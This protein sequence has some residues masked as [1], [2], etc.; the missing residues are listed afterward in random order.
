MAS[1]TALH[2][3]PALSVTAAQIVR[4]DH[5]QSR[6]TELKTAF[7]AAKP[8]PFIILD[9]FFTAA[10]AAEIC[11]HI[12]VMN[13]PGWEYYNHTNKQKEIFVG[14][15]SPY[16]EEV[17]RALNDDELLGFFSALTGIQN[18]V[19]DHAV[20]PTIHRVRRD[21]YMNLHSDAVTVRRKKGFFRREFTV[22]IFMTPDWQA[23]YRGNLELW[24]DRAKRCVESVFPK[25]NRCVIFKNIPKGFHGLPDP[26]LCPPGMSR[27]A[28]GYAG[29]TR[30]QT[31]EGINGGYIYRPKDSLAKKAMIVADRTMV[32]T[33]LNLRW[34]LRRH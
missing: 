25:F 33:F 13:D 26:L 1:N 16:L 3:S 4:L 9:D 31:V 12:P 32:A 5:W 8:Y 27:I 28:I 20:K 18:L 10:A 21:G 34:L 7:S 11:R 30:T 6:I 2:P 15:L 17:C 22:Y 24:D 14:A 29:F 23:G 19:Y